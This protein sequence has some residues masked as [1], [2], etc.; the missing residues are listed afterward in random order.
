[1]SMSVEML[2]LLEFIDNA[3]DVI[4]D[5]ED[6]GFVWARF[7]TSVHCFDPHNG[8]LVYGA[9]LELD[10]PSAVDM[11]KAVRAFIQEEAAG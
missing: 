4:W 2:A 10:K 1:M 8:Q 5:R 6:T 3:D 9:Y 11:F 7:V